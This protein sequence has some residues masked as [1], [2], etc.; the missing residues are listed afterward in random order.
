MM[1]FLCYATQAGK[2]YDRRYRRNEKP[3][4]TDWPTDWLTDK[5]CYLSII[6]RPCQCQ[7]YSAVLSWCMSCR[8]VYVH[9]CLGR[10]VGNSLRISSHLIHTSIYLSRLGTC[11][12]SIYQR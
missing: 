8:V 7:D 9:I 2:K 5:L 10:Q 3:W 12:L 1:D 6:N 11:A 4:L